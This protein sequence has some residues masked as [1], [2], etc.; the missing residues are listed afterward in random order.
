[1]TESHVVFLKLGGSLITDK[2]RPRT[3]RPDV[4]RRIARE[5]AAARVEQPELQI[6][7]GHGSGSFGHVEAL[8][9]NT[10][11]GV[12]N[13]EGWRGFAAVWRAAD[14]LNRLVMDALADAGLP[15]VR[16]APSASTVRENGNLT[17]LPVD[18]IRRALR[19]GLMPV[20]Y[21]DVVFDRARGGGI[22]STEDVFAALAPDLRPR[23]ILLAGV[24]RGVYSDFP[25]G[26]YI[27]P[28]IHAAKW[29]RISA[30]VTGS[31]N[32]DVT[33]GM[34]SKVDGMLGLVRKIR[35]L[36]VLVF[37]GVEEGAVR[38]AL[39]GED[40]PGTWLEK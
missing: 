22:A 19:A 32:A 5:I 2:G 29:D 11:G 16:F 31:A 25:D 35:G 27:I 33:G 12:Q 6:L 9:H 4:L 23:R 36:R 15:A 8:R 30:A 24:E 13:L 1:M 26:R 20:V 14:G 3:V 18:T 40:G 37:S 7:L 17:G 34:Y 39:L 21:G 38:R 10:S 28:H